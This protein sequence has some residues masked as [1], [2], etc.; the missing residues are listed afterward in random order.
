MLRSQ[1]GYWLDL[2]AAALP[3]RRGRFWTM[4]LK[5]NQRWVR[6]SNRDW[7]EA[8]WVYDTM[9]LMGMGRKVQGRHVVGF[10]LMQEEDS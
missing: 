2:D 1:S 3:S 5:G 9:D 8:G 4:T 6:T 10:D 7:R